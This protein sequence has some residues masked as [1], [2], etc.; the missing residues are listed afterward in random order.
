MR[1]IIG[2]MPDGTYQSSILAEDTG[3]GRGDQK[4]TAE[5]TV[6]G[7]DLYLRLGAPEQLDFYTNSYRSNTMSGVYAG[8]MMFAQVEPLRCRRHSHRQSIF[9]VANDVVGVALIEHWQ[10]PKAFHDVAEPESTASEIGSGSLP[11]RP[12]ALPV[13]RAGGGCEES[14]GIG[15]GHVGS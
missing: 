4:I 14:Y 7:D 3:H 2:Q 15:K 9:V 8:L 5:A 10:P 12:R 6:D 1:E 13:G 11:R